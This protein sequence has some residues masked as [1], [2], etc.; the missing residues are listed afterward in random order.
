[1]PL[2]A[3]SARAAAPGSRMTPAAALPRTPMAVGEGRAAAVDHADAETVA[4]ASEGFLPDARA[5]WVTR[6]L[7]AWEVSDQETSLCLYAS[8]DATMRMSNGVI[9]G[10]DSKVELQ[11]EHAGLPAGVTQKFPF[12]SSYRAFRV[13]SSVDVAGLV[14]CQL[15]VASFDADG[16]HQDVT[17]LQLPGVLDDMFAYTGPLG[18]VFGEEAVSLYLWAPTAQYCC[19]M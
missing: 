5:Y 13:P 2:P 19:R 8:R 17:G 1:M 15:A 6:S 16:K 10:Y 4:V 14:K 18:A 7:I 9:E 11:P 12:I 3:H